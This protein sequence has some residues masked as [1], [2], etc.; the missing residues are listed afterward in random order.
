LSLISYFNAKRYAAQTI[1]KDMIRHWNDQK[2]IEIRA[3]ALKNKD[4][5]LYKF[6][7]EELLK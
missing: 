7:K 3:Y 2:G 5:D 1:A 4:K 6:V